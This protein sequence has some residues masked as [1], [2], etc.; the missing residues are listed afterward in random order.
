MNSLLAGFIA[1]SLAFLINRFAYSVWKDSVIVG[2]VP[3]VEEVSKTMMAYF[4]HTS[5]LATHFA[6]GVMEGLI[7]GLGGRRRKL[8]AVSAVL[9]HSLF[10]WATAKVTAE[11][12]VV[13]VGIAAGI[14]VHATWNAVLLFRTVKR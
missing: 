12:G 6:F 1:A 7:D 4:F 9:A 2:A 14:L 3:L 13:G 5:I 8:A 10:G 11:T